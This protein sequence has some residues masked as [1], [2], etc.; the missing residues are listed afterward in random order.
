MPEDTETN[1]YNINA[2]GAVALACG[3]IAVMTLLLEILTGRW[4][5]RILGFGLPYLS[6]VLGVLT[7]IL[8]GLAARSSLR[9][10]LPAGFMTIIYWSIFVVMTL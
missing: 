10:A 1:P 9:S 4:H 5:A 3:L 8:A 2:A 6:V 7:P